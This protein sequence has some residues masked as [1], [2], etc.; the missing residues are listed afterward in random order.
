M[1]LTYFFDVCS[2]WCVL[3]DEVIAE[4]G[5]RYGA[6]VPV[7]WKI[8]LINRGKPMEAVVDL[9]VYDRST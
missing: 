7:S 5:V 4:I 6:R 1:R 9:E 2:V 8:A 3:G